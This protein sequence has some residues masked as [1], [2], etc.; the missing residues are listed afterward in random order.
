[1]HN[2]ILISKRVLEKIVY[3]KLDDKNRSI[4]NEE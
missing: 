3:G 2:L 4:D 1:M